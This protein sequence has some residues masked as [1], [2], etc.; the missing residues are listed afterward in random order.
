MSPSIKGAGI[1]ALLALASAGASAVTLVGLTS[2]NQIVRFDPLAP[3]LS[4]PV[5]LS[6]LSAGERLVGI[7]LRPSNGLIYGIS[8]AQK[9][10]TVNE[11]T[12]A[13]S[14]VATL[15]LP[16]IDPA[17][18]YGID[19]NP[20]ADYGGGTS[21]RLVSTTG[22]NFAVNVGTGVVGNT[23]SNIGPGY[24]AVSYINSRPLMPPAPA[25][26][27][28]YY[29]DSLT[30]RLRMAPGSFNTPTIMDIGALGIDVLRANGFEITGDG[31]AYAALTLD[32]VNLASGLYGIDLASGQ[33][34]LL[35]AYAG[36]LSGLT[37][38]AVPE[39]GAA[40]LL[41][42]GLAA[43]GLRRGRPTPP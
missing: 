14:L 5:A 16:V 38:S 4:T 29:I 42:A 19:F 39:P 18:G 30:D 36:T 31:R 40:A 26:T 8:T 6:G 22:D 33:A 20:V 17:R 28:L 32:D 37:V 34:T 15:S 11:W 1:G 2:A 21:L 7:D 3:N 35:G 23:T 43:I 12:G 10:Y 41:L 24:S 25:T 13:T 9:I 27:A